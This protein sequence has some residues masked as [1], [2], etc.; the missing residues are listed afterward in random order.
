MQ[1]PRPRPVFAGLGLASV[2]ALVSAAS[3]RSS[4]DEF[5]RIVE[6]GG[7]C[8]KDAECACYPGGVSPKHAC[9]GV[10]DAES[11]AKLGAIAKR[12]GTSSGISCAPWACAPICEDRRCRNG[13]RAPR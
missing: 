8:G 5:D 1:R 11:A 10:T 9:G 13:P 4:A 12:V 3:C 2:A 6:Q 7:A